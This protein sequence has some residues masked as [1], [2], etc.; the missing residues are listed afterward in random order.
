M[1]LPRNA[2][3]FQGQLDVAPIAGVFFLLLMFVVFQSSFVST[4]GIHIDLPQMTSPLPGTTDP[5]TVI[6]IDGA[7]HVYYEN[8]VVTEE[9]LF[10]A[11][12]ARVRQT[13]EPMTVIIQGDRMTEL[14]SLFRVMDVARAAGV[15]KA[16][17][18]SRPTD[19]LLRAP[20]EP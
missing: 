8:Q 16:L 12:R 13:T 3:I 4:P 2:R 17:I 5:A 19:F 11:L 14:A 6:S 1:K 18:A 15:E 9:A 10:A 20:E 7:N